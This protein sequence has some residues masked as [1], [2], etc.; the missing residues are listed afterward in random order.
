MNR[1]HLGPLMGK[2]WMQAGQEKLAAAS[3][4]Y[5]ATI[6]KVAALTVSNHLQGQKSGGEWQSKER[7]GCTK[8]C[9]C[10]AQLPWACKT[11]SVGVTYLSAVQE[12]PAGTT[13]RLRRS[14]GT[15]FG[16]Q[17]GC[18][19]CFFPTSCDQR[20]SRCAG[21]G[22]SSGGGFSV[23]ELPVSQNSWSQLTAC[24]CGGS[25]RPLASRTSGPIPP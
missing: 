13:S 6:S 7:R 22:L 11:K 15:R 4:W 1:R 23:R 20:V 24:G 21:L 8:V 12:S 18:G 14:T 10:Q 9:V 17:A 16:E 2:T 19:C 5:M 25:T 3:P